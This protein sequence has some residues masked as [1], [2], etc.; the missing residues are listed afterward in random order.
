MMKNRK[1]LSLV[2]LVLVLCM[3]FAACASKNTDTPDNSGQ[4]Q[5]STGNAQPQQGAQDPAPAGEKVFRMSR[6]WEDTSWDPASFTGNDQVALSPQ[7]FE[8][9]VTLELDGSNGPMLAESWEESADGL[10]L[11]FKLRQGVQWHKGYGEFTSEDVKFSFERHLDPDVASIHVDN[12]NLNNVESIET[13]DTYTVVFKFKNRDV[14]FLA[15]CAQ[16]SSYIVSKKA[17]DDMGLE[18]FKTAPVGTGPFEF[19]K[20]VLGQQTEAVK[21]EQFWGGAA[22]IDRVVNKVITDTNTNYAAFE[23]GE[24][25]LI[26]VYYLDKVNEYKAQG[27]KEY[28]LPSRQLLYVGANMSKEPFTDPKVREAFFCSIDPQYFIEELFYNLEKYPGG[29]IPP[30]CKYALTDFMKANYDPER[31]KQLLAEA[32]HANGL[33]VT[34]WTVNDDISPAPALIVENQMRAAGF[35]LEL[36]LVDFG[37]FI[38]KVREGEADLWLLYNSTPP[39]ADDTINRYTSSFYPGSNWCGVQDAAYDDFVAKA[40]AATNEEDKASNFNE[41][42]KRLAELQVL[43]PVSTYGYYFV[44]Q[45]SLTGV[46]LWGDNSIRLR[47]ADIG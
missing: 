22:K 40:L 6:S 39:L 44:M 15:R 5:P 4:Q 12:L 37:V 35:N 30:T 27:Y 33:N 7:I 28:Y 47:N 8:T 3:L 2:A 45:P 34:L 29:W 18:G 13:P 46:E 38:E 9:L 16:Y 42:Q 26:F 20:G 19:D 23:N 10:A 21:F 25:D 1:R 36:Q 14:D 41:A 17:F 11:T 31:A 32:G 43:Y 24:L